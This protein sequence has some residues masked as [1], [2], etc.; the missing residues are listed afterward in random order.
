MSSAFDHSPEPSPINSRF[1]VEP[2]H[3]DDHLD[4]PHYSDGDT[5]SARSIALSSPPRSPRDSTSLGVL[6]PQEPIITPVTLVRQSLSL[7]TLSKRHTTDTDT[8][9][10]A[11]E[12]DGDDRSFFAR[13]YEDG[14][15]PLSSIAPSMHEFEKSLSTPLPPSLPPSATFFVSSPPSSASFPSKS[16][17]ESVASFGSSSTSYSKK[18]RPESL[19]VQPTK[20]PL[21]LGIA[22]VDFNHVVRSLAVLFHHPILNIPAVLRT[23][24][25]AGP[26]LGP[27]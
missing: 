8:S 2:D 21:V 14:E 24:H 15:S 23:A 13:K 19:I 22:L 25:L 26:R 3:D 9:S 11:S 1:L 10:P 27:R 4:E 5:A 12:L 6:P 17:R 18:A 20:G 7:A 16:D